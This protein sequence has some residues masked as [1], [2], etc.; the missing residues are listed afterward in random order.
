[1]RYSESMPQ[2]DYVKWVPK[3]RNMKRIGKLHVRVYRSTFG[4]IGSRIDGLDI[5]LLTTIG[6]KSG[7]ERVVPLPFF[8]DGK[9]YVLIA[10]FGGNDKNPAWLSNLSANPDVRIQVGPRRMKARA[11]VAESTERERIWSEITRA[12]PRYLASQGKTER[13]IP[14]VVLEPVK[15]RGLFW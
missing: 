13:K 8:R 12:Y 7:E 15:R 6:K 1:M 11:Q 2:T 9:R 10:S 4:L 14:I 5:M 3:E